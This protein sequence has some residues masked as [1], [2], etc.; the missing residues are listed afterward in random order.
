MV[1][2]HPSVKLLQVSKEKVSDTVEIT[3]AGFLNDIEKI[4]DTTAILSDTGTGSAYK[5]SYDKNKIS[6]TKIN[7]IN[8]LSY[9]KNRNIL[10]FVS[11]TFGGDAKGGQIYEAKLNENH[12]KVSVTIWNKKQIGAGGLDGL[13]L[14]PNNK[15]LISDWGKDGATKN[16]KFYMYDI[17]SKK[18]ELIISGNT[19]VA[20]FSVYEN[21]V[22][23]PE[24]NQN[25]VKKIDLP[26]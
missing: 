9:D 14:L 19:S 6:A 26:Y 8:G 22:Y 4:D 20:D 21:T 23:F 13:A 11:S 7:G 18:I 1:S 16:S 3:N 25:A 10:Y 15:L 17:K 12:D 5:T 2:D 24:F